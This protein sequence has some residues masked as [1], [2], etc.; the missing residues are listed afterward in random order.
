MS[1]PRPEV[2]GFPP[3]RLCDKWREFID[4]AQKLWC[5]SLRHT[6]THTDTQTHT[7]TDWTNHMIVVNLRLAAIMMLPG[8]AHVTT[9]SIVSQM[10]VLILKFWFEM[11]DRQQIAFSVYLGE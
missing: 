3:G 5:V 8:F 4:S 11:A 9:L 1:Q 2:I 10:C 7:D 6:H